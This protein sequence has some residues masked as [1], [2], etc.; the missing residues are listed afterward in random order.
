MI[1]R[2]SIA[3]L[4]LHLTACLGPV[5]DLYP[6]DPGLRP[7]PVYLT[8]HGWHVGIVVEADRLRRHLPVSQHYPGG[9]WLEFGWGDADYYPNPDPGVGTLLKAAFLPT[10]TVMHV[11]G[12]DEPVQQRFPYSQTVP[13]QL[14]SA[15]MQAL[16]AFLTDHLQTDAQGQAIYRQE[17]LY[18]ESAFFAA[19]GVYMLPY[20]S[21]MWTARALRTAGLPIT[22]LYAVTQSN[23]VWQAND[24]TSKMPAEP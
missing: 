16:A 1:L 11:V 3:A 12:F 2:S 23:L 19:N 22:P 17:G 15:G 10:A 18:G 4:L 20:T 9:H 14:T 8:A 13:L 21:N 5:T 6:A 24:A 7:V